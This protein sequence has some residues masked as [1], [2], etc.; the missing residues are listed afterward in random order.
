MAIMVAIVVA[1]ALAV[2]AIMTTRA[3][4]HARTI[5]AAPGGADAPAD[6]G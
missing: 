3:E 6:G 5:P 1:I 4:E 2:G